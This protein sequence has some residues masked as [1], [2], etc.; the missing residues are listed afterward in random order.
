MQ[1][2]EKDKV[3]QPPSQCRPEEN[4][5]FMKMR[6][7]SSERMLVIRGKTVKNKGKKMTHKERRHNL[8]PKAFR[9]NCLQFSEPIAQCFVVG[10]VSD[11]KVRG[12]TR[13]SKK[14][15]KFISCTT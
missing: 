3:R 8:T 4:E 6:R 5:I 15:D 2:K 13:E 10:C 11:R 7:H 1:K 12:Q 14:K 9:H